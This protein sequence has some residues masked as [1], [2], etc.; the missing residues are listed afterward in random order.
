MATYV[1]GDVQGCAREFDALLRALRFAPG[2]DRLWLVGDLV[3]RG[4]DSL[5]VLRRVRELGRHATTVLGNH[6]L[7]LLAVA[8]IAGHRPRRR[9]TLEAVLAASDRDSLLDWLRRQPLLHHDAA[10][11]VTMVHAGLAPQWTID[12]ARACAAEVETA[13]L[14]KIVLDRFLAAMYGDRPLGWSADLRGEERLR[15]IT[16]CLTRMR[17]CHADGSLDLT[18]KGAPGSPR[19]DDLLPWYALPGRRSRGHPIVFGHWSTLRMD[20]AARRE[21]GVDPLDTGAVWGGRLSALRLEDRVTF[22]VTS[23]QPVS[24]E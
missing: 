13:L 3:N 24:F 4:P 16:N 20:G 5:A 1:V 9:D 6:D 2:P 18:A 7:H 15:F 19:D 17:Y 11:G 10:L 23:S 8:R 21:Y 14:D 12:D 22:S